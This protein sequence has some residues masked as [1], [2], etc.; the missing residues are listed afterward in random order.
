MSKP[1]KD[2]RWKSAVALAIVLVALP[3]FADKRRSA[4][5]PSRGT[6]TPVEVTGVVTDAVTG[7]PV[8]A[9]SVIIAGS[10]S[11]RTDKLGKYRVAGVI[12]GTGV[13]TIERSGYETKSIDLPAGGDQVAN[14]TVNPTATIRVR[15]VN[16]TVH[17]VDYDSA[18]F[19]YV[20]PFGSYVSAEHED[21]CDAQGTASRRFKSEMRRIIGPAT[22]SATTACCTS[23]L[24]KKVTVEFKDGQTT[25]LSFA[26]SCF[27]G[28]DLIARGHVS[29]DFVY[30]KFTEIAEV[31]FP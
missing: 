5:I 26:D 12:Y 17:D 14:L 28:V 30:L 2:L 22:P 3:A 15:M 1:N 25:E 13:L 20:I 6:A 29:G 21:F 27:Y 19:G 23:G 4:R 31:V 7:Q 8:I 11:S 18:K 24:L 16:G 9:A 10:R